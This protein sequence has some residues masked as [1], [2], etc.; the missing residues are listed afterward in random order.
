MCE[1]IP[2]QCICYNVGVADLRSLV[3]SALVIKSLSL[4][5]LRSET[6][7]AWCEVSSPELI[8]VT[9]LFCA[10]PAPKVLK[11]LKYYRIQILKC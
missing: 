7:R 1:D 11:Y 4:L 5:F 6:I 10:A 8:I 3:V 2:V 9:F